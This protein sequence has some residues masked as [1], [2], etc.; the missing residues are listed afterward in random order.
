MKQK[1]GYR[2]NKGLEG[3]R[4]LILER[5]GKEYYREEVKR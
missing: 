3:L 1:Q 5:I 4:T 2:G